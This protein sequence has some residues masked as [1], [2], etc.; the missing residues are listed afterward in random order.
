MINKKIFIACPISKYLT[1]DGIKKDFELFI[2][3]IYKFCK[4]YTCNVFLALEREKYGKKK[5]YGSECTIADYEEMKTADILIAFPED[6]CG[7]AVEIGWA[8]AMQKEILVFTDKAYKQSEL[9][10]SINS[11]AKGK[12]CMINTTYGYREEIFRIKQSIADYFE[13]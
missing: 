6:S 10:M 7:V 3:D 4:K 1:N 11:I 9:V 12:A 13:K 5:M 8:S 2:R